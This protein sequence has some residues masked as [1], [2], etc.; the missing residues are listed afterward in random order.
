MRQCRCPFLYF[1]EQE[2][3]LLRSAIF[4]LFLRVRK[5]LKRNSSVVNRLRWHRRCPMSGWWTVVQR[6]STQYGQSRRLS[7]IPIHA[8]DRSRQRPMRWCCRGMQ[9]EVALGSRLGECV[10]VLWWTNLTTCD[11]SA[12][13]GA[14]ICQIHARKRNHFVDSG[15]EVR[16]RCGKWKRQLCVNI[17]NKSKNDIP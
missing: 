1:S 9:I 8:W 14:F 4:S 5:E 10:C 13:L 12:S 6:S 17:Q 2:R 7:N 3:K 15:P 11:V 16:V